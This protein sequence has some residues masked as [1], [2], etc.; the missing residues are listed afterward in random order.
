MKAIKELTD[1]MSE[2]I[3][4]AK[5]YA[6]KYLALKVKGNRWAE[7]FKSMAEDE[8]KHA[9]VLHDY[10][11]EEIKDLRAIYTPPAEML[12]KW[13]KAH[14]KYVERAAWVKQMLTM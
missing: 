6:E 1:W 10:T 3:E 5:D 2:E 7:K 14:A 13:D 8:L 12:E 11:V 9:N 4:S